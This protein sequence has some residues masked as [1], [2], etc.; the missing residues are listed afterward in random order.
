MILFRNLYLVIIFF[1]IL[2]IILN[3]QSF[4]KESKLRFD[5]DEVFKKRAYEKVVQL[6][7]HEP[8]ILH[9]WK[10]I[11]D[12]SRKGKFNKLLFW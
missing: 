2:Q 1:N 12:V 9:G 11:C 5:T 8:T 7:A 3:F 6:Q 4:Y 10:L